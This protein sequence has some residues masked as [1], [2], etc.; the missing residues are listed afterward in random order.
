MSDSDNGAKP[1]HPHSTE[2]TNESMESCSEI[3]YRDVLFDLEH[4]GF[5]KKMRD[6][7]RR[8]LDFG[9]MP[10]PGPVL[11]GAIQVARPILVG[12]ERI[13]LCIYCRENLHNGGA[14]A[15]IRSR[16]CNAHLECADE[17]GD[18]PRGW[19]DPS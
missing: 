19:D 4:P 11:Y 13:D 12:I 17:D 14:V 3:P 7:M 2:R 1:T 16:D 6:E 8:A 5:R 10:K 9:E 15:A 18:L